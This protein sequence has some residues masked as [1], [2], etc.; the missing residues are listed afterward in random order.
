MS[1]GRGAQSVLGKYLMSLMNDY[2][3]GHV[4]CVGS[5]KGEELVPGEAK[6]T[7]MAT[8]ILLIKVADSCITL[9]R[10]LALNLTAAL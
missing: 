3:Q 1:P 9:T 2:V 8:I 10:C 7:P 5:N 4:R 6:K